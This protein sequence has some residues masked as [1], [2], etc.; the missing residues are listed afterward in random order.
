[1]HDF[2]SNT[3]GTLTSVGGCIAATGLLNVNTLTNLFLLILIV[4]QIAY[5]VWKWR[6]DYKDRK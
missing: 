6:N 1:M 4:G 2:S 3:Q 5:L